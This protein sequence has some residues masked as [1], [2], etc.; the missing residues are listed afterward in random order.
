M[1]AKA[2]G[3]RCVAVTTSYPA[4]E[5]DDADLVVAGLHELPL[6]RLGALV[7]EGLRA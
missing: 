4:D 2:A 1:P 6:R 5:L 7:E 3:L